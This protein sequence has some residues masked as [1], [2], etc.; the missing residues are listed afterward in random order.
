MRTDLHDFPFYLYDTPSL[1][2]HHFTML[3]GSTRSQ[4]PVLVQEHVAARGGDRVF[5]KTQYS[6]NMP[7]DF[8]CCFRPSFCNASAVH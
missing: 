6:P 2:F 4:L 8:A 7:L 1:L 5:C 3:Q